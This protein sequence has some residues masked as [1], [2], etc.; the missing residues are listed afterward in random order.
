MAPYIKVKALQRE[1]ADPGTESIISLFPEQLSAT[2]DRAV[3]NSACVRSTVT[4]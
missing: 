3:M 2:P 4:R 1:G